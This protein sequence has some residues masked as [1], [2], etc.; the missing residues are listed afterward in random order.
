MSFSDDKNEGSEYI[1]NHQIQCYLQIVEELQN[2]REASKITKIL[3]YS[4]FEDEIRQDGTKIARYKDHVL[5]ELDNSYFEIALKKNG[6]AIQYIPKSRITQHLS[7][8]AFETT[9]MAFQY[10]PEEYKTPQMCLR[11]LKSFGNI[12]YIPVPMWTPE[13]CDVAVSYSP[14]LKEYIDECIAKRKKKV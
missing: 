7:E 8:I 9:P 11:A 13:M 10:I 3:D 1:S 6:Y 5:L 14:N 12:Y 2:E 4:K